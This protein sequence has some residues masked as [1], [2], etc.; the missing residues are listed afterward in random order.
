M[1]SMRAS[2]AGGGGFG[3]VGPGSGMMKSK[4]AFGPDTRGAGGKNKQLGSA[5]EEEDE[6]VWDAEVQTSYHLQIQLYFG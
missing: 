1:S 4:Y 2:S 3:G 5:A 6:D